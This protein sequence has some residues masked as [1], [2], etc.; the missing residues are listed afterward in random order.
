MVR[1]LLIPFLLLCSLMSAGCPAL[2]VGAGAGAGVYTYVEGSLT[3]AYAASFDQTT[4]AA[5]DSLQALKMTLVEE[6]SGDAVKD[7][8]RAQRSDGTPVTVK[9]NSLS[10]D[11][12]EVSVRSGTV[13]YWEKKVSELVHANIAQRLQ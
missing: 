3:R 11:V 7:L 4:Q 5:M 1:Y 8:I 2:V 10:P 9:I 13:G 6:P 12:T